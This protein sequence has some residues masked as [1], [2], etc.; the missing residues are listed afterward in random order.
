MASPAQAPLLQT[1]GTPPAGAPPA[2]A[3]PK[4][5]PRK[6]P[7]TWVTKDSEG[8]RV[9]GHRDPPPIYGPNKPLKYSAGVDS[10][11]SDR[12]FNKHPSDITTFINP[13]RDF[14]TAKFLSIWLGF[15]GA[16][17]FYLRSPNTAFK[18]IITNFLSGGIWWIWDAY[19]F[20]YDADHV[21][22]YGLNY[23]FDWE[24]GGIARGTFKDPNDDE[25]KYV[26]K[27]DF[28]TFT[29][30]A[31][32][33]GVLGADRMYLGGD[34]YYQGWA[35]LLLSIIG[36]GLI[37]VVYDMY[38]V[39]FT[40]EKILDGTYEVPPPYSSV[41]P[42]WEQENFVG[43]LFQVTATVEEKAKLVPAPP[44]PAPAGGAPPPAGGAPPPAGGAPPPKQRGG[45]LSDET[46]PMITQSVFMG[47]ITGV[48]GLTGF[49]ISKY[50]QN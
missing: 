29:I 34:F 15:M 7:P 27:K 3:P 22:K 18:K 5:P 2:G 42:P 28:V 21:K 14:E 41:Y 44:A 9:P 20:L 16:D 30:L 25:L 12:R 4:P 23:L 39:L 31:I 49:Q 1:A 19:H 36:V 13:D 47:L 46:F 50:L 35:K 11:E 24:G 32:F 10:G 45:G 40:P 48:I 17:H 26:S 8:K 43:D 33:L 37:W 6:D 38:Q